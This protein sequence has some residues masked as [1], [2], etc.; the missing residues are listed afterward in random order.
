MTQ[1][2]PSACPSDAT[3]GIPAYAIT[4]TSST[5]GLSCTSGCTRAFVTMN[6]SRVTT[7]YR[8]NEWEIGNS[9]TVASGWGSPTQPTNTC[10]SAFTSDTRATGACSAAAAIRASRSNA[11]RAV[12]A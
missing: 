8:Q 2:L 11:S 5:T 3:S 10:D 12:C 7:A 4:P 6:G 1:K 9:R